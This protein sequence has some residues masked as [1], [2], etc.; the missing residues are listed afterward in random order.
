MAR[1]V[2]KPQ[3]K[4]TREKIAARVNEILTK[5]TDFDDMAKNKDIPFED[6]QISLDS[7]DLVEI[8]MYLE[9][10]FQIELDLTQE[11]RFIDFTGTYTPRKFID[12]M[13]GKLSVPVVKNRPAVVKTKAEH[14]TDKD[15]AI[16]M[17]V[18]H[19]LQLKRAI[20]NAYGVHVPLQELRAVKSFTDYQECIRRAIN[21]QNSR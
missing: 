13:C 5:Y 18:A 3:E 14:T 11:E 21:N 19:P 12:F 20:H 6:Q 9:H 17:H 8:S 16:L 10:D 2:N 1:F 15:I 4:W 7:L